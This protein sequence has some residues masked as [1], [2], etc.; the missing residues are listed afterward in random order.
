MHSEKFK[1]YNGLEIPSIGFGTWQIEEGPT[2]INSVTAALDS[3]YRHID[4]AAV[5]GNEAGVGTAIAKSDIKREDIFLTSK[6][7]NNDRGYATTLRAFD[8]SLN[9]LQ[10][11]YLDLYLIHWPS[12][13]G[14]PEEWQEVNAQTW[15]AM[16]ELYEAGKIRAI[17][18]SNFLKH[19]IEP[20]I[21]TSKIK[22]MV[23]QIEFHPGFMQKEI[24]K[25]CLE[26]DILVEAWSPL[27]SG[28]ML[29]DP[30]LT[31]IASK[32]NKTVAQVCIKWC[33]QNK[34]LP[35]PKSQ[36]PSRIKENLMVADFAI[37]AEDMEFINNLPY[38]G[39][40]GLDPDQFK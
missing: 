12:V 33:L 39:G 5:Y 14:N 20:L 31:K 38:I 6:V 13:K 35:L 4:T 10:T 8:E 30:Q 21:A 17:G 7:W 40:S 16:E 36:T 9:K 18:V 29:S 28:K 15:R 23:N 32:Y 27:G 19:H 2:A 11:D 34:T 3:G 24:Y 26:N 22:P 1:L 37:S 25:F